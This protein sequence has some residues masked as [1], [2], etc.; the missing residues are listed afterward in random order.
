MCI[1]DSIHEAPV[2][3]AICADLH[4]IATACRQNDTAVQSQSL[5]LFLQST[6]DA[7]L[8]GQNLQLA[9]EAE[10]LGAC[11]IGAARNHPVEVAKLLG[12]P[13]HCFVVFGMTVGVPTDD[14]V[15]R[16]R[17]PLD[18]VLHWD[19][20]NIEGTDEVLQGADRSM[21]AWAKQ[22][23]A[24]QGG[25]NGRPINESKGWADRMARAWGSD[26]AGIKAREALLDELRELGF[27]LG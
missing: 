1:R 3:F 7:S 23:N 26:N 2:F 21:R 12:L 11:M 22:A 19:R 17:M 4:K 8:L 16:G 18:G 27:E 20:Y 14:P 10:G 5:E 15:R 6:V 25:Y 9:A 24:E 13:K